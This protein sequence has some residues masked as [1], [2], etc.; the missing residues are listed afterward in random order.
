MA[1]IY[2]STQL[3]RVSDSDKIQKKCRYPVN[4]NII[5]KQGRIT[6]ILEQTKKPQ[7]MLSLFP[8]SVHQYH[9]SNR[10]YLLY[11]FFNFLE[12]NLLM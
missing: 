5:L 7:G 9:N 10:E 12:Y 1:S 11:Y 2:Q 4:C 6:K 8:A 3:W